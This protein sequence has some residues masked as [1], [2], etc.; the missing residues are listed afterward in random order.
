MSTESTLLLGKTDVSGSFTSEKQ[1][2][3]GYHRLNNPLHT[4]VVSF[5]NWSGELKIQATLSLYPN[6]TTDWIDLAVYGDGSTDYDQPQTFNSTGN[7]VWIR[8]TGN[9]S[10]GEITEIRYNY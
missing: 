7:Y 10:A 9:N 2:G 5:K 6:D 3:A 1:K 8:A 4:F